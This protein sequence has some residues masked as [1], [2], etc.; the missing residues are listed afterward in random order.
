M[1][2]NFRW[3]SQLQKLVKP[4]SRLVIEGDELKS[5]PI[6]DLDKGKIRK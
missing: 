3:S 2:I 4:N 6:K 5:K 1:K